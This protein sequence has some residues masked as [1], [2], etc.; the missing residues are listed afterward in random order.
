MKV[1]EIEVGF[2]VSLAVGDKTWI[3]ANAG[4][5]VELDNP[6]DTTDEAF[7][8]SW[9]RVVAEVNKQ[10]NNFDVHVMKKA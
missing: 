8:G 9:N 7:E 2:G 5:K 4:M 6:K 3:K 10:L 1:K